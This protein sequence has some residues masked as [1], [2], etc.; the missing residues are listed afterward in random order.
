V[1]YPLL[2]AF[3]RAVKFIQQNLAAGKLKPIIAKTFPLSA[4]REAHRY[5]QSNQ[6]LGKIVLTV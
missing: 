3:A 2:T 5:M 6:Q 1:S 4:L